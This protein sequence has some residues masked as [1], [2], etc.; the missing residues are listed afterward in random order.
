[1]K[2]IDRAL[3]DIATIRSQFAA[4]AVFQGFGPAVMAVTGLLAFLTLGLQSVWPGMFAGDPQTLLWTW[5]ITAFLAAVLVCGETFARARRAHGGLADALIINAIENFL[6]AGIAGAAIAFVLLHYSPD[7]LWVLPGLWQIL[8]ALGLFSAARSLPG[9]I[10]LVGAWY[11]VCGLCVLAAAAT[12]GAIS[13]WMMG[14]PFGF[15]QLLAAFILYSAR[16]DDD[17]R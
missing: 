8:V 6:P 11:L 14:L 15:G 5:V 13:P 9:P 2:D 12:A 7:T 17:D 3:V 4:G 10:P 16:E 1:M